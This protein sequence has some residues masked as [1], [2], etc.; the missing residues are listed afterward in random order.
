[1]A[2]DSNFE[3]FFLSPV[4]D[5]QYAKRMRQTRESFRFFKIKYG[6]IAEKIASA[7][8]RVMVSE[9]GNGLSHD[10]GDASQ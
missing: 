5:D 2:S 8:F 9:T 1:M 7:N 3:D 6:K 10:S 4:S